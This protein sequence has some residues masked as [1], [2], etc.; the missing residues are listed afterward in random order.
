ASCS[1]PKDLRGQWIR[2]RD[3]ANIVFSDTQL[4]GLNIRWNSQ[5]LNS[6]DCYLNTGENYI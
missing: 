1:F 3:D 5:R 2:S 6:F 4:T